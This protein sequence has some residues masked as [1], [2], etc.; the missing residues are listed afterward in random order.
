MTRSRRPK[1]CRCGS[2]EAPPPSAR[3]PAPSARTTRPLPHKAPLR[4]RTCCARPSAHPAAAAPRACRA[5]R[6][7]PRRERARGGG[8]VP[9]RLR[10]VALFPCPRFCRHRH[11]RPPPPRSLVQTG[12]SDPALWYKPDA[13][14]SAIFSA[15]AA[16]ERTLSLSAVARAQKRGSLP[17]RLLAR[18]GRRAPGEPPSD[19]AHRPTSAAPRRLTTAFDRHGAFDQVC[20][21]MEFC[22]SGDLAA[23]G[24]PRLRAPPRARAHAAA[25][26]GGAFLTAV[27]TGQTPRSCQTWRARGRR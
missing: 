4:L 13:E 21:V 11:L 2:S 18:R 19:A 25:P 26:H 20:T 27:K 3:A 16:S 9:I 22:R 6:R 8:W 5:A 1:C 24:P 14:V 12:R 7:L 10:L 23:R 15:T 17:R